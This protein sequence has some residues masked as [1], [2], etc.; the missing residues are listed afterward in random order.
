MCLL[1]LYYFEEQ[2]WSKYV[3]LQIVSFADRKGMHS[4]WKTR[5]FFK[6]L[7]FHEGVILLL[8][9][10]DKLFCFSIMR[11]P[12]MQN[13]D[14]KWD[15]LPFMLEMFLFNVFHNRIVFQICFALKHRLYNSCIICSTVCLDTIKMDSIDI[16]VILF[17]F[18]HPTLTHFFV[19]P[20]QL[21]RKSAKISEK[22][23]RYIAWSKLRIQS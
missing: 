4:V 18:N 9:V 7:A 6:V 15:I 13:E 11:K 3:V 19:F 17:H 20:F 12:Q 16:R 21:D 10:M 22:C 8:N 23:M 2:L 14:H 5:V 1:L